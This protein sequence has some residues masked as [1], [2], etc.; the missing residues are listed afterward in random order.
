ENFYCFFGGLGG[1]AFLYLSLHLVFLYLPF[2]FA[3]LPLS[4]A[5]VRGSLRGNFDPPTQ[6]A[7]FA[8]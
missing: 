5:G 2:A 7:D 8:I 1:L 3:F 6:T 4:V